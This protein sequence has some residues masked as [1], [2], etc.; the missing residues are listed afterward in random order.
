MMM[1]ITKTYS[2]NNNTG[3]E[4]NSCHR[5][6]QYLLILDFN[7]NLKNPFPD[8]ILSLMYYRSQATRVVQKN[9]KDIL[10]NFAKLTGKHRYQ[11]L[12][13]NKVAGMR[14]Y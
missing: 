14:L 8:S 1:M 5:Q 3:T 13:F 10:R 9:K 11:S 7:K 6:N 4:T 12:F 2:K